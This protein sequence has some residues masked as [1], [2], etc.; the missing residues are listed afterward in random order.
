MEKLRTVYRKFLYGGDTTDDGGSLY[1]TKPVKNEPKQPQIPHVLQEAPGW[2]LPFNRSKPIVTNPED[3]YELKVPKA[4]DV[5]NIPIVKTE[6]LG[7]NPAV[8]EFKLPTKNK[9]EFPTSNT[10]EG[11]IDFNQFKKEIRRV[12][13]DGMGGYQAANTKSSAA[14]AYQFI[15]SLWGDAIGKKT[16]VKTKQAF[17][18][19]PK[20]QEQFMDYYLK[21]EVLPAVA[22]LRADGRK[23]GFSD[24]DIAKLIH[25]QGA[26]G[27]EKQL[28]SGVFA[29]GDNKNVSVR[30]YLARSK[31]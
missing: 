14:G 2:N 13:S 7:I 25:F 5:P 23:R 15:W 12:E 27:A 4:D 18:N 11:G 30:D 28:K 6:K 21:T 31:G 16:G 10:I 1:R 3:P 9:I 22:R 19:N 17:L 26:K 24:S 20:A 29:K 8:P